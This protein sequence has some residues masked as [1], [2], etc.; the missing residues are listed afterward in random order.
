[1][2]IVWLVLSGGNLAFA[3]AF[4]PNLKPPTPESALSLV[5]I[6][7]SLAL[8]W[9]LGSRTP[10]WFIHL[11]LLAAI[12]LTASLVYTSL[13]YLGAALFGWACCM[14]AMYTSMWLSRRTALAYLA[15]VAT[16]YLVTLGLRRDLPY[17]LVTWLLTMTVCV[18]ITLLLSYLI[19]RLRTLATVDPLTGLLN[20][21]GLESVLGD[22]R[23]DKAPT[24][25]VISDLDNFKALNDSDGHLAGDRLLQDVGRAMRGTIAATD[26]AFRTG[27]DEFMLIL[28]GRDVK[29]A[30]NLVERVASEIDV[31]LSTGIVN[32]PPGEDFDSAVSRADELMYETKR[33]RT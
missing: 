15:G 2:W 24:A 28:P 19:N 16:L 3:L 6:A 29:E 12:F 26:Y 4:Q 23:L 20:R 11:Q 33:R 27:G 30:R 14:V 17:M 18:A 5:W 10:L 9:I 8:L 21:V 13:T 1:M 22:I 25:L 32:W 7:A 31:E